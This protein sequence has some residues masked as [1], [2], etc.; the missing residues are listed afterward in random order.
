MRRST[1][2]VVIVGLSTLFLAGVSHGWQG[3]MAG[4][5][6]PFGLVQD[7]S[8]FLIHPSEIADGK[9]V[10]FYGN[11]RF[12]WRD[13]TDW[14]Y[15]SNLFTPA[16]LT[17]IWPYQ[18][19]GNDYEHNALLGAAFPLGP[20]RTGLFFEYS[21]RRDDYDGDEKEHFLS[22]FY[23]HTYRLKSDLD[24]FSLRLLYGLPMGKFKLGGEVQ[25]AYRQEENETFI[26]EDISPGIHTV[27]VLRTN[28][29]LGG[30]APWLNLFP[31]MTP[32][33]SNYWEAL[34]KGSLEGTIGSAK[35]AFTTRGGFIFSGESKYDAMSLYPAG[36]PPDL[37]NTEGDVKGWRIGG[38]FW[39]RV[40]SSNGLSF[41]FLVKADY[42]KKTRDG[43]GPGVGFPFPLGTVVGNVEYANHEQTLQIEAGGGIDKEFAGRTR[44]AAGIY[45]GYLQNKNHVDFAW[46]QGVTWRNDDYSSSPDRR[47]NQVIVKLS[48]EKEISPAVDL[49]MGINFFYGWVEED[50]R[51]NFA[52]SLFPLTLGS[53]SSSDGFHWGLAASLGGTVRF[54]RFSLEPFI[55][56]GYQKLNLTGDGFETVYIPGVLDGDMVRKEWSLG[57]G[58]SIRF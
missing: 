56:G 21:G 41:P 54:N 12:N 40:P 34:F 58:L 52:T 7:E 28:Y 23:Y 57:G 48:G 32:Y 44:V 2:F 37:A 50:S 46:L 19:S 6:D 8:D 16:G 43:D 4:M 14:N 42:Q 3:R 55:I 11:Y 17:E 29:P 39:L 10:N 26:N 5:G 31:F 33:N 13:V 25:L 47:E 27:R 35:M 24:A 22:A 49:R 45:Y 1:L 20:G 15:S 53:R 9:G 51:Y 18:G 36:A 30:T 38:D